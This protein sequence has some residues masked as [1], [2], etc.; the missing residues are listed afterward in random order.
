MKILITLIMALIATPLFADD[1][2]DSISS[3]EAPVELWLCK[4]QDGNTIED[5]RAWYKDFN[6]RQ[7]GK[8]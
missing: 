4:Y 7:D 3:G 1:H 2:G 8:S 5:L 6:A